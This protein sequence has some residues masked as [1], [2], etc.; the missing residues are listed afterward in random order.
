VYINR[1]EETG[2]DESERYESI[3]EPCGVSP[4]RR[5]VRVFGS[6]GYGKVCLIED[7]FVLGAPVNTLGGRTQ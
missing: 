4:Y 6:L 5:I 3:G 2:R 7:T 1:H